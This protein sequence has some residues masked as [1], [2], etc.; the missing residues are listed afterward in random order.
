MYNPGGHKMTLL[1]RLHV[2]QKGIC[3]GRGTL[4]CDPQNIPTAEFLH[5]Y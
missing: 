4:F 5:L 3:Q 2:Y 1:L